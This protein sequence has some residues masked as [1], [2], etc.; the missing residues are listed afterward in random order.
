MHQKKLLR[1]AM[2]G[3]FIGLAG[4]Q[5]TAATTPT[6]ASANQPQTIR[7]GY[8][9]N[10]THSQALIGLA[11]GDFQKALGDNVT[12]KTIIFNA[13]PSE[14]EA[15]FAGQIDI[16]YIGPNPSINGYVQSEGKAL[17]IVAG[18]TSGGAAMVVRPAAN[19][20]TAADLAGKKLAT[21]Q[22]GN[23][24]DVAL[25]G[26]LVANGLKTKEQGGDVD[27]TPMENSQTLD[28][29]KQGKI[30]GAWV[31]EPWASRLIVEGGGM[32]FLDERDL[33]KDTN[34]QFVTANIIVSTKFLTEHP[35]LVKAWLTAHV[36]I[37]QWEVSNPSDAQDIVNAEIEKVTGKK[38]AN[39]VITQA[40]GRMTPTWDP[41]SLSLIKSAQSAFDAGFL[42][43]KPDLT[44]IYD[45]ILLNE[46]LKAKGL[47]PVQ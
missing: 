4:C 19:I 40:W 24:Q 15:M 8:F 3:L 37:T 29:F 28:L 35:D 38:L 1:L 10:L 9:A 5:T 16:G 46:I 39:A 20:K 44:G 25:R 2:A 33:W 30:D 32:L 12:I 47:S 18:A 43:T 27:V 14:I 17:R 42:K 23:T 26:Y 36:E 21:P 22:L 34:G 41:I 6:A 45:L 11:R 13:G 31:P 7:V